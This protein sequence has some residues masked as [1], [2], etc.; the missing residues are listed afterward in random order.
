MTP[1]NLLQPLNQLL[2]Q[3]QALMIL[4]QAEAWDEMQSEIVDY[5]QR[6][7]VLA[8]ATY[9]LALKDANLTAE[10]QALILQIQEFN[11]QLDGNAE[12][13]HTNIASE[14]RQIIQADKALDAYRR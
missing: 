7:A 9:L 2:T 4:A 12:Q 11:Q 10:A 14:L 1:E 8:D 5:Q 13:V 3:A 6:M